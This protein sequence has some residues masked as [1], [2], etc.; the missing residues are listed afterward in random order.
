MAGRREDEV[1][2]ADP[3]ARV[4]AG[5]AVRG[6][7]L[8]VDRPVRGAGAAPVQAGLLRQL[9]RGGGRDVLL[10]PDEAARQSPAAHAVYGP[11]RLAYWQ[12][13][14]TSAE[15]ADPAAPTR[16]RIREFEQTITDLRGRLRNQLLALEDDDLSPEARRHIARRMAELE[17]AIG[18]HEASLAR[19][20]GELDIPMLAMDA[21][22]RPLARLPVF[23]ERLRELPQ[24]ELRR[25]FDSLDLTITYHH[26]HHRMGRV[27]ITLARDA[28][29]VRG[30]GPCPGG[31]SNARPTA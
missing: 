3:H 9:A 30:A 1:R 2:D 21:L 12:Q 22:A 15:Q 19:L 14:V 11:D 4:S 27:T 29:R 10:D 26:H 23:G 28:D 13:V 18:D 5:R 8:E 17:Q 7:L 25:L 20:H 24:R 6:Q 16:Q 31:D